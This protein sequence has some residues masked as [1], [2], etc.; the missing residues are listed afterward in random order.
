MKIFD[1]STVTADQWDEIATSSPEA[2][3]FHESAWLMIETKYFAGRNLSF[4]VADRK[5]LVAIWPLYLSDN[6]NMTWTESLLH[7]GLHR[8]TGLALREGLKPSEVKS[9]QSLCM[10]HIMVL[11]ERFDV[12]RIQL[13]TQ[14]LAAVNL[15]TRR[16]TVPFWVEHYGFQLGISFGP[17]CMLPAPGM[18]TC[19]L[20]QIISLAP[21]EADLFRRIQDR[22]NV[23]KAQKAGFEIKVSQSASDL[24]RF[25]SVATR[26]AARTGE[27]LAPIDYYCDIWR[28]FAQ[29]GRSYLIFAERDGSPAATIVLLVEKGSALY[30]AGFSDPEFLPFRVNNFIH[31]SAMI[32]LKRAGVHYYRLGPAFPEVPQDWPIAKVSRFK[33]KFGARGVPVMQGSHFR[34]PEKYAVNA[35]RLI[36]EL[37]RPA[38]HPHADGT[39]LSDE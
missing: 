9:V 30:L 16:E 7:C 32:W 13:N 26:S 3:L 18:T 12:D 37:C 23:R 22:E 29:R 21:D 38:E 5:G 14:N 6:G 10:N 19:A 20:D 28:L 2:W 39:H 15:S 11:G 27:S 4:G 35:E 1:Y 31:W 25:Y 8:H 34:K 24:D 17:Y 36:S 33:T